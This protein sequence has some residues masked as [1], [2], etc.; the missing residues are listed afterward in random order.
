MIG[1]GNPAGDVLTTTTGDRPTCS[2]SGMDGL[3]IYTDSFQ[4]GVAQ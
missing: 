2:R 3:V 4:S 1:D